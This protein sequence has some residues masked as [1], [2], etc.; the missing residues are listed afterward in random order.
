MTETKFAVFYREGLLESVLSDLM[1][2]AVLA[3]AIWFSREMG[4]GFW[5]AVCFAMLILWLSVKLPMETARA[6][7]LRSKAD[8]IAWAQA[9]PDEKE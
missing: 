7:K 2:L 1:S 5:E 9:L 3:F 4:G 6:V 8:A